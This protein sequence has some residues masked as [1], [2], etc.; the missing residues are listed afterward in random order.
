MRKEYG[1]FIV[2]VILIAFSIVP[3]PEVVCIKSPCGGSEYLFGIIPSIWASILG[4]IL[5]IVSLGLI[6]KKKPKQ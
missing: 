2:G 6:I 5:V 1:L 3:A 4:V